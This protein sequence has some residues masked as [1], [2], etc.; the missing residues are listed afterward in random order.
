VSS[1][2]TLAQNPS[3][4]SIQERTRADLSCTYQKKPFY[5]F[6]WFKQ[7]PGKGLVSLSLIQ[8]SQK[9][10]ADKNF[11]EPLG[12]EKFIIFCICQPPTL[13]TQLPTSVLCITVLSKRLQPV[14]QLPAGP[15]DRGPAF[16]WEG[17]CFLYP[18]R[19]FS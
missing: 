2:Y 6:L 4:L 12:K 16:R 5:N 11:K 9:E 19:E 15:L 17:R 14:P 18:P 7:E 8:S 13:Q 1:Q 3:F 10:Q